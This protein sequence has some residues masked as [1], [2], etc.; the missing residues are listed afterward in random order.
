MLDYPLWKKLLVL[1]VSVWSILYSAVN[2]QAPG[3]GFI[4]Q[5]INLGLDL[6]GGSYLMLE[7][8]TDSYLKEQLQ[9]MLEEVR[10][11]ARKEKLGYQNLRVEGETVAL[12]LRDQNDEEKMIAA[13]RSISRDWNIE[14]K[15][16][17]V[18]MSFYPEYRKQLLKK[19]LEQSIEIVRRRVD[20]TGT[21]EPIIQRQGENRI[22]LQV[23]GLRDTES[24]KRML[25]TTAKMTFHLM[26][27]AEPFPAAQRAVSPEN[28]LLKDEKGQFYNI[29]KTSILTGDM[30]V[31]AQAGFDQSSRPVVNF[32]FNSI[33]AKKFSDVT[34]ENTGKPFAIVLDDRVITAPRINEPITGGSGMISGSFTA[35][36]ANELA[37]LLRAGALPAPL[38]V[39]E[40]RSVGPSLGQDSIDSGVNAVFLGAALVMGFMFVSY[41]LFGLFANIALVINLTLVVACLTL[42]GATLTMPGIAGMVL[43][44]GMSVDANVLIFERIRE[45]VNNGRS[46]M[47]AVDHGFQRAF[48]TILDS[49]MTG[50]ISAFLLYIFGAGPIKGFA[51]TLSIG[52][53]T[54]LF[55]AIMVTRMLIVMYLRKTK[56]KTIRI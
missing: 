40:E 45:E 6:K 53:V 14:S 22:L 43:M 44:L 56:P 54:S 20:Q 38:L 10:G 32:R 51:V 55:S 17:I 7:L 41:L 1:A 48:G 24:L 25:G 49:H 37:L 15:Q 11:A 13:L 27:E 12:N 26:D 23:P 29:V 39:V 9:N 19:V 30:L 16:G 8:G 50:L 28:S 42:F 34:R 5:R 3:E 36:S 46:P 4:S 18:R 35:E 31:D 52:I 47:A 2:F 21:R 33:G